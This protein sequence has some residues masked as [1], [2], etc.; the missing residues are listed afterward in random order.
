MQDDTLSPSSLIKVPNA[1][2]S[3]EKKLTQGKH[4]C[5][6]MKLDLLDKCTDEQMNKCVSCLFCVS[7]MSED[8]HRETS[9]AR[10]EPTQ[11]AA[12]AAPSPE[13]E[14]RRKTL[15]SVLMM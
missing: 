12:A 3:K 13:I 7:Q 11:P 10:P 9:P 8:F 4:F 14:S 15:P 1:R 2:E 6:K 5:V